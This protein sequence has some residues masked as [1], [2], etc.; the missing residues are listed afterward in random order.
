[1]SKKKMTLVV[2][3]E[4]DGLEGPFRPALVDKI[5]DRLHSMME[6][7]AGEGMLSPD[8]GSVS[9]AS[10]DAKVADS[11]LVVLTHAQ[12]LDLTK[13]LEYSAPDEERN[14]EECKPCRGHIWHSIRR[15]MAAF[16]S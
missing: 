10:W 4:Y 11:P 15:L 5:K 8:D 6:R 9:V 12:K 13:L 16:K 2:E 1:M 7:A 14:Y 3:I